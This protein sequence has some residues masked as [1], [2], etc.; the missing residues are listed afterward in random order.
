MDGYY[1]MVKE[2]ISWLKHLE[3]IN[4]VDSQVS[5]VES[6]VSEVETKVENSYFNDFIQMADLTKRIADGGKTFKY[7]GF[8]DGYMTI[9]FD[10]GRHDLSTV[11]SICNEFNIPLC[12]AIPTDSLNSICDDGRKVVDVCH[13]IVDNGGE[14]LSHSVDGKVLTEE[15]ATDVSFIKNMLM[16]S[17]EDLTKQGF[18]IRGFIRPG[19]TGAI[20]WRTC[21]LFLC[22]ADP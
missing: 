20:D 13:S 3:K 4:E 11:A 9:I 10:D 16:K 21:F 17:K 22:M 6:K 14:I 18:I 8:D 5:E 2:F 15:R 1:A 12:C 19:G 7:K